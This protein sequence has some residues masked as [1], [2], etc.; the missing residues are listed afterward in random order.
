M[1][2]AIDDVE[3]AEIK[4]G[5]VVTQTW[6]TT[7]ARDAVAKAYPNANV[8]MRM[9]KPRTSEVVKDGVVVWSGTWTARSQG[10]RTDGKATAMEYRFEE[11]WDPSLP[12][13]V[14]ASSWPSPEP[15]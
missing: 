8:I 4:N 6:R 14:K 9:K 10:M 7:S 13:G 15:T 2:E 1:S 11:T 12:P 5:M 3:L